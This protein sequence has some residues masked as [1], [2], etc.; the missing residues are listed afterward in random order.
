M[1][2]I[3]MLSGSCKRDLEM[4]AGFLWVKYLETVYIKIVYDDTDVEDINI[5]AFEK[6]WRT[7]H[8]QLFRGSA[9]AD[10]DYKPIRINLVNSAFNL[11]L[12]DQYDKVAEWLQWQFERKDLIL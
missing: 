3:L 10:K 11:D 4:F 2:H 8:L 7:F 12:R 5:E 1:K 6:G 9:K